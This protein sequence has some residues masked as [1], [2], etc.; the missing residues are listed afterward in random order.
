MQFQ[1]ECAWQLGFHSKEF[2][3]LWNFAVVLWG[4]H[5]KSIENNLGKKNV[6]MSRANAF[7][8]F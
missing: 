8:S 7:Y 3:K 4:M 1:S 2:I 5:I 6:V